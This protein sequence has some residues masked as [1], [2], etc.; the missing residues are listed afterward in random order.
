VIHEKYKKFSEFYEK[1]EGC[2]KTAN[3]IKE[4]L[5]HK[6]KHTLELVKEFP[7]EP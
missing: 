1:V 4:K 7:E 3:L 6:D 5:T 2:F